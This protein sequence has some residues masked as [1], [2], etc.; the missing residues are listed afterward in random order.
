VT[1]LVRDGLELR[2]DVRGGSGPALLL[3]YL[4]FAWPDYLDL[5]PFT[6]RFTVIIASP[7]G[8]AKSSR[9]DAD[10]PY[11]VGDLA[12]DLIAVVQAVGFDRFFVLGYSFTGAFAPARRPSPS[13]PS[14]DSRQKRQRVGAR[15][16]VW[17]RLLDLEPPRSAYTFAMSLLG[18]RLVDLLP[19]RALYVRDRVDVDPD[20]EGMGPRVVVFAPRENAPPSRYDD[21]FEVVVV[22][23]VVS[24]LGPVA[25]L[26]GGVVV[27]S[28]QAVVS[29]VE[30]LLA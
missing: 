14:N 30:D 21:A 27:A 20:E 9:L 5:S 22:G 29:D 6:E 17:I 3:P 25:E 26:F 18:L 7:R 4:N 15:R 8:F 24:G 2:Y 12:D 19:P 1:T 11:R 16:I 28:D 23:P 10:T 13:V